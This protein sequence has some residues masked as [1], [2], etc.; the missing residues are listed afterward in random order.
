[1]NDPIKLVYKYKNINRTRQYMC[2]IFLGKYISD[3]IKKIC[4]KIKNLNFYDTLDKISVKDEKSMSKFFGTFWYEKFFVSHHFMNHQELILKSQSK[5]KNIIDKFGNDWYKVH[6]VEYKIQRRKLSFSYEGMVKNERAQRRVFKKK[7]STKDIL[8][9]RTVKQTGGGTIKNLED[10]INKKFEILNRNEDENYI[11]YKLK[12]KYLG[13]VIIEEQTNTV[14]SDELEDE[15]KDD[16]TNDK[17]EIEQEIIDEEIEED[18]DVNE[19]NQMYSTIN[20]ESNKNIN[21]TSKLISKAIHDKKWEQKDEDALIEFNHAKD[22]DAYDMALKDIYE[23]IYI[24]DDYI[25]K[26]DNIQT[27]RNRICNSLK[28]NENIV[29]N[30]YLSPSRFY[31]WT[32]YKWNLAWDKLMIGQTWIYRNQLLKI[33]FEPNENLKVY[34]NL[35]GDLRYFRDNFGTKV[36]R[37]D[38]ENK[39]LED[40][41]NYMAANEIYMIDIYN[42]IGLN[43]K[44]TPEEKKNIF[45]VYVN[46]YFPRI[47]LQEFDDIIEMVNGKSNNEEIL[48]K[49]IFGTIQNDLKLENEITDTVEEVKFTTDEHN[50]YFGPNYII[51]SIIHVNLIDDENISGTIS[52]KLNLYRVYNSFEVNQTYPFVIFQTPDTSLTFKLFKK[53]EKIE[54]SDLLVKWFENA[55]YGIAFKVKVGVNKFIS[56]SLHD[57]QKIEYRTTWKEEDKATVKDIYSSYEHV[58]DLVK[59]INLEN[60]RVKLAV[61]G[62]ERF[63]YAFI[64]TILQF[65]LPDKFSIDHNDLSEFAPFFFPYIA[66]VI[67]PRKRQSKIYQDTEKS[68]KYGTYLRFKRIS[69]YENKNKMH[70]R[71]LYFYRNYDFSEKELIDEMA[72]QFNITSDIA[73]E[74]IAFVREKFAKAISRSRKVLKKMKNLPKSKP[75][76]IGLDIVG[77][78]R[79][80]YKIRITGARS[81]TQL[82]NIVEFMKIFIFLYI[83]TYLYKKKDRQKLK[84]KLKQLTNIARRKNKVVNIVKYDTPIKNVKLITSLDKK[85]LGF[86]PEK[87]QSQ[88]TRSCQNSGNDKKRRPDPFN[89][90]NFNEMLKRGYIYNTKTKFYEKKHTIKNGKKN[91]EVTL[92]AIKQTND[93]GKDIYYT[94]DPNINKEHMYVGFLSKGKNPN[95]LCMPCCFK[96]DQMISVNK[97]KK[98]YFMSC[99]G[100]GNKNKDDDNKVKDIGDKLYILQETNKVQEGRFIYLPTSL[101]LLFNKISNNDKIIRNHY[102]IESKSGYYFKY[103]VRNEHYHFIA[104]INAIF[105]ISIKD[106]INKMVDYLEKDKNNKIFT[107]LNNGDIKTQFNTREKFIEY[108][109]DANYLGIDLVGD[110]LSI[111]GVINKNGINYLILEKRTKI[112]EEALEKTVYN[113]NY[114]I[115]CVNSENNFNYMDESRIN[116]ILIKDEKYYFPIFKVTRDEKKDKNMILTKFYENK[117]NRSID[118]IR[119]FLLLNCNKESFDSF[120]GMVIHMCKDTIRILDKIDDIK[121]V[122]QITDDR[123]KCRYIVTKNNL[124]IPVKPSGTNYNYDVS[125]IHQINFNNLHGFDET[126]ELFEKLNKKAPILN[127]K[128]IGVYFDKSKDNAYH[129]ISILFINGLSTPIYGELI[130]KQ[131]IK[132]LGLTY[133]N[134]P[135]SDFIDKEIYE[136]KSVYD[137]RKDNIKIKQFHHESYQ[138]FR[139]ELSNHL[140]RNDELKEKIVNVIENNKIDSVTVKHMIKKILYKDIDSEIYK[141]Y[142]DSQVGGDVK[143]INKWIFKINKL[144]DLKEYSLNNIRDSCKI[145]KSENTC[146]ANLH[147]KFKNNTCGLALTTEMIIEFVNKITEEIARKGI[148]YKEILQIDTYYVSDIRDQS[149]FTDKPNQIIIKANNQSIN[150]IME[151]LF[152]K[153]KVPTIGKR[154]SRDKKNQNM[155]DDNMLLEYG[156]T[157]VQL[158]IN[159]NDTNFRA[160][161]NGYYWLKNPLHNKTYRNIGYNSLIQTNLS[162]YFKAQVIDYLL[163]KSDE[164]KK[165]KNLNDYKLEKNTFFDSYIMK[166]RKKITNTDGF[167]ELYI[168]SKIYNYPIVIY[169]NYNEIINVFDKGVADKSQFTKYKTQESKNTSIHIKYE[170]QHEKQT[171]SKI[172]AV[173]Y[174]K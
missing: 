100:E 104:A 42:E 137:K 44:P 94:C 3:D 98:E 170:F 154:F 7:V 66:L 13:G 158:I 67:E 72:K 162:Y 79:D 121:I 122:K 166:L 132:K 106:I 24:Y 32:M 140:Q 150:K 130:N 51:Q 119:D 11:E 28:I 167:V 139:L 171:P 29:K 18:F 10:E 14:D 108:I 61:P 88:W 68:S 93:E 114:F 123:N 97:G 58:R 147:C 86:K 12:K 172:Y 126:L 30:G 83:E 161:S 2:Y 36:K 174:F 31:L 102:L 45:D 116:I 9:F 25:F 77:R 156:N 112:I 110:L 111:P 87:G 76:G 22:N 99:I 135:F 49:N 4:E 146:V 92:K 84:D 17:I 101:E 109:Q 127:L 96:K 81:Q 90:D 143:S 129:V 145:R 37:E 38:D 160:F 149:Q 91:K 59:K 128:P 26:N 62:D 80:R 169:N 133:E 60:K 56:I 20:I 6:F 124:Y 23:K 157:G 47:S 63:R 70:I 16:E 39:I 141:I 55:P 34:E 82:E 69:K 52:D 33:D 71:I 155:F 107:A 48:I 74:E 8:D 27:I 19:L 5:K 15:S 89:E 65:T 142:M 115:T 118:I 64:N 85:R 35:R 46:V 21:E 136:N 153:Q 144:H 75:P 54:D 50:K 165:D 78:E 159:N 148:E 151:D 152:G 95:E 105:D 125:S 53:S 120:D 113:D 57:T 103:T 131:K 117:A 1:M 138:L 134:K 168:L 73:A 163:N 173:Y 40:Y 43:Y 164:L 41:E